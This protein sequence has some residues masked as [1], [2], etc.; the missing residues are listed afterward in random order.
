MSQN[1]D[2]SVED[3]MLYCLSRTT[4]SILPI[5]ALMGLDASKFFAVN[6]RLMSLAP[7]GSLINHDTQCFFPPGAHRARAAGGHHCRRLRGFRGNTGM[8][9]T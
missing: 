7:K 8:Q 1:S 5:P 3:L 6:A 4:L 9:G 2:T